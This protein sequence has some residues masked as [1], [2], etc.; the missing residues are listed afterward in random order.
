MKRNRWT[1]AAA[2]AGVI[3]AGLASRSRLAPCLPAFVAAYAGDTLWALTVFL[4]LGFV[5]RGLRPWLVA[6]AALI[7]SFSVEAS[8]FYQADWI[9]AIRSTH[10]GALLLGAGFKWSDLLCYTAG[11]TIGF[12]GEMLTA[13]RE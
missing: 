9:N 2:I 11:V 12:T 10:V 3:I 4:C 13:D 1:Y 8:Q 6:L 5:F 7:I